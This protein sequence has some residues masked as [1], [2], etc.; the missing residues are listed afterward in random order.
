[1]LVSRH[2]NSAHRYHLKLDGEVAQNKSLQQFQG[3]WLI[4]EKIGRSEISSLGKRNV[5]KAKDVGMM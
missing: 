2:F 1:M 4:K 3:S 5:D